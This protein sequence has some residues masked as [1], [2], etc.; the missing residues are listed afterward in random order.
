MTQN[1]SADIVKVISALEDKKALNVCL[2]DVREIISYADFMIICS[3]SST[4]HVNSL[5]SS[6]AD[7]FPKGKG[8]NYINSSK[9]DSWWILDFVDVVV[10]VFREDVHR[11]YDLEGLWSDAKRVMI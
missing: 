2:L 10:H 8:P 6:V 11:Y 7:A 1:L 5:V 4:T 3:G 9:D